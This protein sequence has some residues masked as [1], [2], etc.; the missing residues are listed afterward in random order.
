MQEGV[1]ECTLY[2]SYARRLWH[3]SNIITILTTKLFTV[4]G[5]LEINYSLFIK[6]SINCGCLSV[7]TWNC[8]RK[9]VKSSWGTEGTQDT[10]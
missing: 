6:Q 9:L 1:G 7:L 2:I 10:I 8:S 5:Y 4:M 3:I